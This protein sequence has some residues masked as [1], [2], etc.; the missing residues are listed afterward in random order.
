MVNDGLPPQ[1]KL[2]GLFLGEKKAVLLGEEETRGHGV[3]PNIPGII[4]G[5]MDSQPL[6]KVGYGGFSGGISRDAGERPKGI[7]HR[8]DIDD[9]SL[10]SSHHSLSKDLIGK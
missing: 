1:S 4:L 5:N 8:R 6:G 9:Y 7:L 10:S 2:S 3:H